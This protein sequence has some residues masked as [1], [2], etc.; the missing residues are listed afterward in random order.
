MRAQQKHRT[1]LY[2][3]IDARLREAHQLNLNDQL[4]QRFVTLI[5]RLRAGDAPQQALALSDD[6]D[7]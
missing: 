3:A 2:A 1:A 5:E 4:P 7:A 6:G